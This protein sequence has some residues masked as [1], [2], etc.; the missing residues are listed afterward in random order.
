MNPSSAARLL[1]PLG[2][3]CL[4]C[5][6][7]ALLLQGS[8]PAAAAEAAI[9]APLE[10]ISDAPWKLSKKRVVPQRP[11]QLELQPDHL[12][13]RPALDFQN[14]PKSASMPVGSLRMALSDNSSLSFR[15]RSGGMHVTY[16]ERF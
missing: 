9:E 2:A 1:S 4:P 14:A 8:V 16:R 6:A 13:P 10:R 7:A 11:L 15:P 5:L 3:A 12:T